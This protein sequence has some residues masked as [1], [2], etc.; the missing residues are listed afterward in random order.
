MKLSPGFLDTYMSILRR[1]FYFVCDNS[2]LARPRV[3]I[4]L[5]SLRLKRECM[6]LSVLKISKADQDKLISPVG[7]IPSPISKQTANNY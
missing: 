2:L 5:V 4:I 1:V 3:P 6:G 7:P